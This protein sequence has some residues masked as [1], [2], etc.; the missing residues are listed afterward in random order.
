M[1]RYV[2]LGPN[3]KELQYGLSAKKNKEIDDNRKRYAFQQ[4]RKTTRQKIEGLARS[5]DGSVRW[6][7]EAP[8]EVVLPYTREEHEKLRQREDQVCEKLKKLGNKYF[9]SYNLDQIVTGQSPDRIIIEGDRIEIIEGKEGKSPRIRS[10]LEANSLL[11]R[12]DDWA[13]RR[14]KATE[15]EKAKPSGKSHPLETL[16]TA[17]LGLGVLGLVVFSRSAQ[18]TGEVIRTTASGSV[19]GISMIVLVL[20]VVGSVY[21]FNARKK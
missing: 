2:R 7:G 18:M 17:C 9:S 14:L 19:F 13:S 1:V 3:Q 16:T 5:H 4:S 20:G 6:E 21:V 11:R 10:L 15:Y 12:V 8:E